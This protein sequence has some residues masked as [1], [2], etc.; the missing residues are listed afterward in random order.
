MT[1]FP[2]AYMTIFMIF[3]TLFS[4][5]YV[6]HPCQVLFLSVKCQMTWVSLREAMVLKWSG[7]VESGLV[8]LTY[9]VMVHDTTLQPCLSTIAPWHINPSVDKLLFID[10]ETDQPFCIDFFIMMRL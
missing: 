1:L 4:V 2:E 10:F 5:L 7:P 8:L 3:K 9:M 6:H